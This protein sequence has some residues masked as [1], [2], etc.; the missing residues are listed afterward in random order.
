MSSVSYSKTFELLKKSLTKSVPVPIHPGLLSGKVEMAFDSD[1]T[2]QIDAGAKVNAK[3]SL[4]PEIDYEFGT[5]DS[6][7]LVTDQ[8]K[9]KITNLIGSAEIHTA[10]KLDAHGKVGLSLCF[11]EVPLW[12]RP[13]PPAKLSLH[14]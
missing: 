4:A 5:T 11:F 10:V 2:L 9:P 3:V 12:C 14:F 8:L 6:M 1:M 13:A 7:G